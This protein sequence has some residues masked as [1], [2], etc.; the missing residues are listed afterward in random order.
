[1]K[2]LFA[3]NVQSGSQPGLAALTKT[4]VIKE[5]AAS[6]AN[7]YGACIVSSRSPLPL[8][9]CIVHR[10]CRFAADLGGKNYYGERH[11]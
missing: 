11:R 8:G 4:I 3:N 9:M 1:M 5:S 7:R 2:H 10:R 6:F